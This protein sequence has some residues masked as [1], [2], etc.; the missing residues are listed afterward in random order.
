MA[1]LLSSI[2]RDEG[3]AAAL[4]YALIVACIG[5]AVLAALMLLQ[6]EIQAAWDLA[7]SLLAA[8]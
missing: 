3:G 6:D 1:R 7:S 2:V 8:S 4:E 5:F